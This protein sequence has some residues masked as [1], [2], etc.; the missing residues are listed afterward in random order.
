MPGLK[1]G[2]WISG[3]STNYL[4]VLVPLEEAKRFRNEIV[5]IVPERVI[6]DEAAGEVAFIGRCSL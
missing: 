4:R 5:S 6:V 2:E 1:K 3:Y